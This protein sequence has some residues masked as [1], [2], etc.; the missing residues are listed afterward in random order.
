M[1]HVGDRRIRITID[2]SSGAI[3]EIQDL[4][5]CDG[6]IKYPSA[7]VRAPFGI[8]CLDEQGR[9]REYT[10]GPVADSQAASGSRLALRHDY[11]VE[12][13]CGSPDSPGARTSHAAGRLTRRRGPRG[14]PHGG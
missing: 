8:V 14:L 3:A 9:R 2:E 11:L 5:V 7:A 1:L 4:K 13:G 6:V 12:A 10:A